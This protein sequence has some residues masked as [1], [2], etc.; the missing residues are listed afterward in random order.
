MNYD[1]I[2]KYKINISIWL[3]WNILEKNGWNS[4]EDVLNLIFINLWYKGN[5]WIIYVNI[6]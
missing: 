1:F 2:N 5:E 3:Y 4:K 6:D